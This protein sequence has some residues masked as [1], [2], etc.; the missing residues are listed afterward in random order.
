MFDYS[1]LLGK[2]KERCGTHAEFAA[3]MHLSERTIS[4]KLNQKVDFSQSEIKK[5][6]EIL[7]IDDANIQLYF[8]T[9]KVQ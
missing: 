1:F 3:K 5:A 7:G 9:L 6:S 4:Q 8:F 2:I